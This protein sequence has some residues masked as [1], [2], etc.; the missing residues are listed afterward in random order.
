MALFKISEAKHCLNIHFHVP[1]SA[2][3]FSAQAAAELAKI[4]K[5]YKSWGKPVIVMSDH[6]RM[7]CSGG[8]LADYKK[9]KGKAPGLKIN[10]VIEKTLNDFG[11]WPVPKIAVI[12]G[13]VLGGGMEWLARFDYRLATPSAFLAFWQ[14]RI[15]L[16]SGWGGGAAWSKIL[17]EDLVRRL[18]LGGKILSAAEAQRLGLI[19]ELCSSWKIRVAALQLAAVLD[20]EVSQD[21]VAWSAGKEDR[22]FQ[23]L[24]MGET[25]RRVLKEWK[26]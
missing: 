11:A 22:V 26:S 24:W 15:G 7:F 2:N 21:L 14:R 1:E 10:R 25:H 4:Q 8:N 9:L 18:L 3:A 16:S 20:G 12:E 17:G 23:S 19:D 5:K 13:D 6:P